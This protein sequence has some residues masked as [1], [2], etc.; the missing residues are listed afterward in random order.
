MLHLDLLLVYLVTL[1]ETTLCELLDISSEDLI[2]AFHSRIIAKQE[3]LEKEVEMIQLDDKEI[4]D[5]RFSGETN[6]GTSFMGDEEFR[7]LG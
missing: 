4:N 3:L 6:G 1:D 5:D 2:K 7:D